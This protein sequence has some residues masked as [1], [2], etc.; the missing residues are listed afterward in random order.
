MT[1]FFRKAKAK[2]LLAGDQCGED[3]VMCQLTSFWAA[4]FM[5]N[6]LNTTVFLVETSQMISVF[7][8]NYKGRPWMKVGEVVWTRGW[9]EIG[10]EGLAWLAFVC[11]FV[12]SF[13]CYLV[14]LSSNF[15]I[16]HTHA[17]TH[18]ACLR[19][20]LCFYPCLHAWGG[21]VCNIFIYYYMSCCCFSSIF[22]LS[23][24]LPTYLS[25]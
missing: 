7:F 21:C 22:Y 14:Q 17:H 10:R 23:V 8:A 19:T 3:D 16:S 20:T 1:E 9:R 24:C 12:C 11:S 18:R 25:I 13:A 15:I 5:P 4:P 6:L 2:E